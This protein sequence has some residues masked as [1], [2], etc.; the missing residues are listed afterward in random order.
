[1]PRVS[2]SRVIAAPPAAVW[3]AL[4]DI[5]NARRWNAAWSRIEITSAQSSGAGTTFRAHTA[6]GESFDFVVS[7]WE[8]PRRISFTP[9][10]DAGE[11]YAI[12]LERHTF[13]LEPA[14]EAATR[15]E[16]TA[17]ASAHGLMG[18]L[19][20]LFL[21]PGHQRHGLDQALAALESIFVDAD[22]AEG[23]R[24]EQAG[25]AAADE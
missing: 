19:V 1:M 3:A 6:D 20:A 5:A 2:V 16:L 23:A 9:V 4:A 21:W 17:Q 15:V 8:A 24:S 25:S 11:R 22:A 13:H 10:R 14:G 7:E 12:M 18:R